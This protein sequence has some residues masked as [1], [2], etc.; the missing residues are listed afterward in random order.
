MD[1]KKLV[2]TSSLEDY[3][4]TIFEVVSKKGVA[5][6]KD[7]ASIRKVKTR[8]CFSGVKKDYPKPDILSTI[9][10]NI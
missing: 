6:V 10:V 2:L 7:I 9:R 4:K 1:K 3:L 8:I 5:R